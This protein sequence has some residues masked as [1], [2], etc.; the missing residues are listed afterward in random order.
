MIVIAQVSD[1][2]FDGGAR[3]AE[4]SRRVLAYLAALPHPV[5][6]VLVTGDIADHGRP[7][8]YEQ[9]A[10]V[11][12]AVPGALTLPGNHDVRAAYRAGLLGELESDGPVNRVAVVGGVTLA[13]CDSTIPGRDDGRLDDETLDWLRGVLTGTDGPVLICMHHPPVELGVPFIDSLRLHDA[14]PLAELVEQF[15]NVLA[16]LCG[17]AHSPAATTFAGRP[18]LVAP[19]VVSRLRLPW[20]GADPPMDYDAPPGLAFHVLD[21]DLRLTTHYRFLV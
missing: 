17:H 7:P 11:L 4:R 15:P 19:G 6:V 18:L 9:A 12:A 20:E 3:A 1:T 8:E 16:V 2:H 14:Q 21:D 10:K 5:D 13:L